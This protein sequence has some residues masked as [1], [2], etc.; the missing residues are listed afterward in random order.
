MF[1]SLNNRINSFKYNKN[2]SFRLIHNT[3]VLLRIGDWIFVHGGLLPHHLYGKYNNINYYNNINDINNKFYNLFD[4]NISDI[5]DNLLFF[6][7][8]SIFFNR[9]YSNDNNDKL[10]KKNMNIIKK[11]LKIKGMIVGHS[12]QN[13]INNKNDVWRIDIGL[14]KSFNKKTNYNVLEIIDNHKVNII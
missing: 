3:A 13:F 14:S 10:A 9:L 8:N 6:D 5:D 12:V 1:G 2:G 7:D 4:N 11:K